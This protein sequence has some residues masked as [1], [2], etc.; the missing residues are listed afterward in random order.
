MQLFYEPGKTFYRT[1]QKLIKIYWKIHHNK[2]H[3]LYTVVL[4]IH[5]L[6]S[7]SCEKKIENTPNFKHCTH[8]IASSHKWRA[9]L[10]DAPVS[11]CHIL[12]F[13]VTPVSVIPHLFGLP[14]CLLFQPHPTN[15]ADKCKWAAPIAP[16]L[17]HL[18]HLNYFYLMSH[19]FWKISQ[20]E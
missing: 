1:K 7:W 2:L 10:K 18:C 9:Y 13:L 8:V 11:V 6:S 15:T 3:I 19:D 12:Q 5:D 20:Q 16:F 17:W 14:L 4:P